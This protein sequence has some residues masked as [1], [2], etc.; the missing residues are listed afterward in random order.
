MNSHVGGICMKAEATNKNNRKIF[1]ILLIILGII[2]LIVPVMPG[3]I[4]ILAGMAMM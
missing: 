2:G 1:G 4:F 3:W